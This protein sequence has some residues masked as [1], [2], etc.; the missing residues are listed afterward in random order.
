M[1]KRMKYNNVINDKEFSTTEMMTVA[2]YVI[3]DYSS[4]IYEAMIMNKKLIFYAFDLDSYSVSRSFFID[5]N[6]ELPGPIIKGAKEI[7]NF[8]KN[9]DYSN[10]NN[11]LIKKYVDKIK[12]GE[13][14][15]FLD[16]LELKLVTSKLKKNE[17]IC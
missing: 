13:S 4:I 8:I 9:D 3:S 5:Y 11:D 2:E 10:Y 15:G 16:S 17:Y 7:I 14:S 6:K 1:R 12:R